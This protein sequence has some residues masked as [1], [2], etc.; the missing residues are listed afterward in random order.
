MRRT[1]LILNFFVL[2]ASVLPVFSWNS[3]FSSPHGEA[4]KLL[5]I[6]YE[7]EFSTSGQG[8]ADVLHA[9][10]ILKTA[11]ESNRRS[12]VFLAIG[13]STQNNN[14]SWDP[15]QWWDLV[16]LI[17]ILRE[18]HFLVVYDADSPLLS[19]L[20]EEKIPE[21][22]R[23]GITGRA[24]LGLDQSNPNCLSILNPWMR[25][26]LIHQFHSI[27]I[28]P[29]SVLGLALATTGIHAGMHLIGFSGASTIL[30]QWSSATKRGKSTRHLLSEEGP[31]E[32]EMQIGKPTFKRT[33]GIS[34]IPDAELRTP[35]GFFKRL[36][37]Q[38][39]REINKIALAESL[40]PVDP[41]FLEDLLSDLDFYTELVRSGSFDF[42]KASEEKRV[43]FIGSNQNNNPLKPLVEEVI[44]KLSFPRLSLTS[45]GGQG[46]MKTAHETANQAGIFNIGIRLEESK[47]ESGK[48]ANHSVTLYTRG[49]KHLRIPALLANQNLLLIAPGG[50]GTLEELAS[51]LVKASLSPKD[52]P[53]F[54]FLNTHFWGGYLKFLNS[55]RLPSQLREKLFWI[56]SSEELDP[57]L[58]RIFQDSSVAQEATPSP[59]ANEK[60]LEESK[61][62]NHEEDYQENQWPAVLSWLWSG[63]FGTHNE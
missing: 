4:L 55:L 53:T 48:N 26:E 12:S 16:Q 31:P 40:T 43:L 8:I 32:L 9:S 34:V 21:N 60:D 45:G 17:R 58:N 37:S 2:V 50:E 54:V 23:L 28:S 42:K 30:D 14:Q 35:E 56:N 22:Y 36:H 7:N 63:L 19:K 18:K 1:F 51:A 15:S 20:V 3:A 62:T 44:R 46:L 38:D 47:K 29:D 33:G 13:N 59:E 25:L 52:A 49:K 61:E 10:Y 27:F 5:S 6:P 39:A 24:F 11:L 41:A 57:I